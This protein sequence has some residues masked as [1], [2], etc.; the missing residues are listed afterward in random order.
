M[1]E[2]FVDST[3]LS[4]NYNNASLSSAIEG[5]QVRTGT[6]VSALM[7]KLTDVA[8]MAYGSGIGE[9]IKGGAGHIGVINGKVV[10]FNTKS[11]E[12]KALNQT[13][14]TY[15]QMME[16]SDVLR[17]RLAM[18]VA[19]IEEIV[20]QTSLFKSINPDPNSKEHQDLVQFKKEAAALLGVEMKDGKLTVDE[21]RPVEAK[22]SSAF[23]GLANRGLLTRAAAAKTVTLIRDFLR[24]HELDRATL[25]KEG[26]STDAEKLDL[27]IWGKVKGMKN[28]ASTSADSFAY[29]KGVRQALH[30][31][32]AV[33]EA[34]VT[35][36]DQTKSVAEHL[37]DFGNEKMK[38]VIAAIRLDETTSSA[39]YTKL[40]VNE[41][42]SYEGLLT[43][44]ACNMVRFLRTQTLAATFDAMLVRLHE[45]Y[46]TKLVADGGNPAEK[47]AI[48]TDLGENPIQRILNQ[49]LAKMMGKTEDEIKNL[50]DERRALTQ[51]QN[52]N[53]VALMRNELLAV[54]A[55][56]GNEY[57]PG[58][59]PP[60]ISE[61]A[62]L[63]KD[64]LMSATRLLDSD[65]DGEDFSHVV[66]FKES[67]ASSNDQKYSGLDVGKRLFTPDAY[68]IF[69]EFSYGVTEQ[70]KAQLAREA[71]AKQT[72]QAALDSVKRDLFEPMGAFK[73]V[74]SDAT[75][76]L[77]IV[78]P[79]L[80]ST[81]EQ[82]LAKFVK[83]LRTVDPAKGDKIA[84]QRRLFIE[85]MLR[86]MDPNANIDTTR[87]EIEEGGQ[88]KTLGYTELVMKVLGDLFDQKLAPTL[89]DPKVREAGV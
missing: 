13:S 49:A 67:T 35:V 54:I 62:M 22:N 45:L 75:K 47:P 89:L 1:E 40:T 72:L 73:V 53:L 16:A 86:A 25:V 70:L 30:D 20:G 5:Q 18:S 29:M 59:N 42:T 2:Q 84:V 80:R 48:L 77:T 9:G 14:E 37:R 82:Q 57:V 61:E 39:G 17:D 24:Q 88:T 12:R 36:G 63:V 76:S 71:E 38:S 8:S 83:K 81:G 78:P 10:K 6:S 65:A 60:V 43:S 31:V 79:R 68:N 21:S 46:N 50:P 26:L 87:F 74:G 4:Q 28:L 33:K 44:H 32:A 23:K 58:S 51:N 11:A 52:R 41:K 85:R 27:H 19:H 7:S 3:V 56:R 15:R 69:T 55:P 64:F 66:G 34:K